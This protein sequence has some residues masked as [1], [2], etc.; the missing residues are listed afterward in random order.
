VVDFSVFTYVISGFQDSAVQGWLKT[1]IDRK[2]LG[3][4][5]TATAR[6]YAIPQEDSDD[7]R[8]IGV[9]INGDGKAGPLSLSSGTLSYAE[10]CRML[11]SATYTIIRDPVTKVPHAYSY[12]GDLWFSYENEQSVKDKAIYTMTQKLGGGILI[13]S[14]DQD[15]KRERGRE[16]FPLLL[17]SHTSR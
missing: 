10:I 3:I 13:F 9:K 11:V 1:S 2:K 5:V 12:D 14:T 17:F 7:T 15:G 4:A 6:T 16:G 8:K